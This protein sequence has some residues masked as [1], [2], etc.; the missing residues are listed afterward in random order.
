MA[1]RPT[2]YNPD[3][4][5]QLVKLLASKGLIDTEISKELEIS[6]ATLNNWKNEHPLFLESIKKGK[7][8][9][10]DI[11]ENALFKRAIGYEHSEDDIK[12]C[13]KKIVITPTIKHYPPD[14]AAAFIWLKNRRP[15]KWRD[16]KDV[17]FNGKIQLSIE[18]SKNI[19]KE[20]LKNE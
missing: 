3:F 9:I 20:I 14:T 6:E 4:H 8:E 5:P 12:V 16:K 10:D 1:G 11:V 19:V 17:D 7:E 13:D 2:K 15:D 18:D